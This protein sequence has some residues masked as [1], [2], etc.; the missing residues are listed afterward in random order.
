M[1][2]AFDH[3]YLMREFG[4]AGRALHRPVEAYLLGGCALA[5]RGM[6]AVTR[7]VDIALPSATEMEDVSAALARNGYRRVPLSP[8]P[9]TT[10]YMR[11]QNRDGFVWELFHGTIYGC[12]SLS[13][14]MSGRAE[15]VQVFGSLKVALLALEDI[16]LFKMLSDRRSDFEDCVHIAGAGI[17]WDG[18][19]GESLLQ[20]GMTAYLLAR[21]MNDIQAA[22]GVSTP[23]LRHLWREHGG[24][25]VPCLVTELLG[26]DSRTLPELETLAL[27]RAPLTRVALRSH[28]RAMKAAGTITV[29]RRGNRVEYRLGGGAL[30]RELLLMREHLRLADG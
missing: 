21:R 28:L 13:P 11:F 12:L 14:G 2:P 10:D 15:T 22:A 5:L 24:T 26:T 17:D 8:P 19:A 6:K 29:G 4:K 30:L 1:S 25:L 16:L 9:F 23:V 3:D 7:D 20:P 18:V 27:R